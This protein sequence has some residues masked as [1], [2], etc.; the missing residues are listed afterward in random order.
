MIESTEKTTREEPGGVYV[1][2]WAT[3]TPPHIPVF[4]SQLIFFQW[5]HDLKSKL[6]GIWPIRVFSSNTRLVPSPVFESSLE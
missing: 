1:G 3:P 2:V 6:A 4:L 5:I